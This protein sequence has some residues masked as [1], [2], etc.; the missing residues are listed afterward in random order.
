MKKIP[1]DKDFLKKAVIK[2]KE[3]VKAGGFPA[4][5]ILV[6]DG[7]IIAEGISVG[8]QLHDPTSHSETSSIRNACKNLETTDLTSATLYASLQP[9]LMC[10]SVSNWANIS[11]IVYGCKKTDEMVKKNYYEGFNNVEEINQKNL[12][13]IELVYI[14]DF[15][16]EMLEIIKDWES[17]LN[18]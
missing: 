16:N 7:K 18:K 4:G 15:E 11:K 12:R 6:Q 2:A 1:T 10:F 8:Y 14:P 13:Q 5:A 17:N 9:Y 3:S